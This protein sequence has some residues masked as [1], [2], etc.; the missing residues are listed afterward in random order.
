VWVEVQD[1][2]LVLEIACAGEGL[3]LSDLPK[4]RWEGEMR[5]MPTVSRE[6]WQAHAAQERRLLIAKCWVVEAAQDL[7]KERWPDA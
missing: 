2:L 1:A 3:Q 7:L 5:Q 4:L 6:A